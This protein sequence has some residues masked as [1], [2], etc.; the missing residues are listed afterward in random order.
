ML[1]I[2]K[3]HSGR[4]Y[5]VLVIQSSKRFLCYL[6]K[7]CLKFNLERNAFSVAVICTNSR[8]GC[9]VKDYYWAVVCY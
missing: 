1:K 4:W 9:Y 3:L 7:S 2:K 5:F 8:K 6:G